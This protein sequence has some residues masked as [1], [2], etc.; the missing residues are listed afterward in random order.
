MPILP[1]LYINP[2]TGLKII[3]YL[4]ETY[5]KGTPPHGFLEKLRLVEMWGMVCG[6]PGHQTCSYC[7]RATSSSEYFAGTYQ[8]PEMLAHYMQ[9]RAYLPPKEFIDFIM[10]SKED[11]F[12]RN[13]QPPIQLP[14]FDF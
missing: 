5:T 7:A 14:E 13:L 9:E 11:D 2:T 3:G 6:S 10:N 1:D 4:G 8:W 12:I